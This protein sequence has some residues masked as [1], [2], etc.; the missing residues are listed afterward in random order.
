MGEVLDEVLPSALERAVS[1]W[2]CLLPPTAHP[3]RARQRQE[4]IESRHTVW[5]SDVCLVYSGSVRFGFFIPELDLI[6]PVRWLVWRHMGCF[7]APPS[8]ICLSTSSCLLAS[9]RPLLNGSL[10]PGVHPACRR[11]GQKCWKLAPF[12]CDCGELVYKYPGSFLSAPPLI[13]SLQWSP[14][15]PSRQD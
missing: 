4:G 2:A 5:A 8:P 12:T 14:E 7:Q 13:M 3:S 9:N 15:H 1:K 6:P 10:F 11:A